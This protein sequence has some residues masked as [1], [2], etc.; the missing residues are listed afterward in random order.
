L[1]E[2]VSLAGSDVR[3]SVVTDALVAWA[4]APPVV[5]GAWLRPVA[6]LLTLAAAITLTLW[7]TTGNSGPFIDVAIVEIAISLPMHKRLAAVLHAASAPA[8]DLDVLAV[9]LAR[10]EQEQFEAERVTVLQRA[11]SESGARASMAI[12][13]L[14]RFIELHDW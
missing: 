12:R 3:A 1:R 7:M 8:H 4:E 11:L 13:R 10:L 5:G 2:A 6:M 9:V 14:H